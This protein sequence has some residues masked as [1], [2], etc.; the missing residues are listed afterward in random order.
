[1][2]EPTRVTRP[3]LLIPFASACPEIESSVPGRHRLNVEIETILRKL[4]AR[5]AVQFRMNCLPW[6]LTDQVRP[7]KTGCYL[8]ISVTYHTPE[9]TATSWAVGFHYYSAPLNR[10]SFSNDS[11]D[12][13]SLMSDQPLLQPA[14]TK[15]RMY[16]TAF[17]EDPINL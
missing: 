7:P 1:M 15:S 10:W 12:S 14:G 16:W 11:P 13:F 2:K 8:C 5:T 4:D 3:K 6:A 17:S 9:N